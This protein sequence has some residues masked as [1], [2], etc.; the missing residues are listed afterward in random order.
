MHSKLPPDDLADIDSLLKQIADCHS[1][2]ELLLTFNLHVDS[3]WIVPPVN[4]EKHVQ[5]VVQIMMK[6]C[7]R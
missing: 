4:L 7:S 2:N 1:G 5:A 3:L 6:S